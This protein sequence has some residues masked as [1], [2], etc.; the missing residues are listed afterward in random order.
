[1]HDSVVPERENTSKGRR[2]GPFRITLIFVVMLALMVAG[3]VVFRFRSSESPLPSVVTP[4]EAQRAREAFELKYGRPANRIDL[5]SW[6]AEWYLSQNRPD[7]AIACFAEVPTAHPQYGHMARLQE[8]RTLFNLHRAGGAEQQFR[9]LIKAE[10]ASPQIAPEFLINARQQLRHILEVELR[11]EERH[12]LL[13]G[14]IDRGEEDAF[15]AVAGCFPTM[16]RWNGPDAIFWHAQFLEA[17]PDNIWVKISHG[18][19]LTGQGKADEAIPIL[20]AVVAAHPSNLRAISALV[21]ALRES[22]DGEQANQ[23]VEGL[24][25]RSTDD[26]WTLLLQ[27]GSVAAQNGR[28]DE[29]RS[30]Y[31]Q[32]RHSD[33]T[34]TEC[35]QGLALV[36]RLQNDIQRLTHANSMVNGLGRIQ[37]HLGKTTQDAGNPNSF[38]DVAELCAEF[39]LIREGAVMTRF[40]QRL[41]PDNDRV[42]A[43][44]KAFRE[45]LIANQLPPL[46]GP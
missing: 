43:T 9:E 12:Q 33:A 22:G 5:A 14:V 29:A 15:E 11:F 46:L 1:M 36:A 3:G 8:G 31:D 45:R 17:D 13:K 39:Q 35:W 25:P 19:Y 38:L 2:A 20:Q 4:R 24:P 18:R 37:N 41:S 34:S 42:Q 27:R 44:V 26:P 32:L 40:A 28:L 23:L 10:E 30:A 6:L 7:D 21:A 16:L